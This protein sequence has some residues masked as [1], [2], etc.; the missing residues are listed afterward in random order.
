MNF[1]TP[2]FLV[3]LPAVI[4]AY[5]AIPSH[6]ARKLFLLVASYYFYACW[7]WRFL[8]LIALST[9]IDYSAGWIMH[10]AASERVRKRALVASL[11]ANLGIL[12]A[13]K[14]ANFFAASLAELATT[15]GFPIGRVELDILLPIGISFY[16]F[17]SM[18][19]SLDLYRGRIAHCR[20]PLDFALFVAFFPQLVAGPIVRAAEFLPQLERQPPF[21][22]RNVGLGL[23]RV[24]RGLGKKVV[25]ADS[26]AILVDAIYAAPG[27][28]G[29]LGAWA[30][31]IGF[32]FQVYCDFSGYSDIAIGTALILGFKLPQ[33]FDHPYLSRN[34]TEFWR[35]WHISLSSWLRDY[36]YIS[37][38]GNRGGE[39]LTYR[40][41][42]LTLL[43]AGLWH[44]A[45]WT[46][47][48][49]GAVHG[50]TLIVERWLEGRRGGAPTRLHPVL[51]ILRTL[52]FTT[53]AF[54]FFR[55]AS[56]PDVLVMWQH[57]AGLHG[58]GGGEI[59][60]W[61]AFW[62]CLPVIAIHVIHGYEEHHGRTPISSHALYRVIAVTGALLGTIAFW[63]PEPSAFIYFQF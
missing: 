22:W 35:R 56:L 40:N 26:L 43:L 37:L 21:E 30:G 42:F 18:S 6:R 29:A 2:Q 41:L 54:V 23:E 10:G 38:G 24:I 3:F 59:L 49:F 1:A 61:S 7:D 53:F 28:Y 55:A 47:V 19:Y 45:A 51:Q 27:E 57:M 48:A 13:F 16:T 9:T 32:T 44:G 11:V 15:V 5:W 62:L 14:Y 4:L 50:A 34:I 20:D 36:L 58:L 46:F 60:R 25:I 12:G 33:N 31:A 17:Q 39:L 63:R 52:L 8:G